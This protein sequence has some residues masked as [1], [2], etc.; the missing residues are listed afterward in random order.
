[1]IAPIPTQST[2]T[3]GS[4]MPLAHGNDGWPAA[5]P[6]PPFSARTM[7]EPLTLRTQHSTPYNMPSTGRG[8]GLHGRDESRL[9]LQLKSTLQSA[10]ASED[11]HDSFIQKIKN[12]NSLEK[13][14]IVEGLDEEPV[15]KQKKYNQLLKPS[16]KQSFHFDGIFKYVE[17]PGTRQEN[18]EVVYKR[19][20]VF[21]R[22]TKVKKYLSNEQKE[23][24][25]HAFELFD[26]DKS[27]TIDTVELRDAMKSLGVFL[28]KH[29][30]L[31]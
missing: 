9:D 16:D 24:I 29:E 4:E 18:G 14:P 19:K 17:V 10:E 8:L 22:I 3:Q 5:P 21:R 25:D 23:E 13:G 15:E 26:K 20:R 6:T 7:V 1:M 30:V 12:M 27:N 28:K 11:V 31:H 2:A